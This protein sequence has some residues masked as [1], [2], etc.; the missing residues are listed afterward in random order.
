MEIT[1]KKA[2]KNEKNEKMKK[3]KQKMS[4]FNQICIIL[5]DTNGGDIIKGLK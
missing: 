4:F 2:C 1:Q 3:R 5:Q